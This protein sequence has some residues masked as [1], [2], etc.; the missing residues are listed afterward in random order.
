V[1]RDLK[2]SGDEET[3]TATVT[4]DTKNLFGKLDATCGLKLR[5]PQEK[6][7]EDRAKK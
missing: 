4:F 2:L 1:P 3:L 5:N 6:K 7:D